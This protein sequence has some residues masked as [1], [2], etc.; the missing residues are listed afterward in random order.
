MQQ[1]TNKIIDKEAIINGF[2]KAIQT[3]HQQ[4]KENPEGRIIGLS[5][6]LTTLSV[7]YGFGRSV[8]LNTARQFANRDHSA[9]EAFM[10][11]LLYAKI[12]WTEAKF[13]T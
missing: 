8:S 10:K 9:D 11:F 1:T 2:T 3:Y 5:I 6:R 13:L 12:K 4:H 7:R